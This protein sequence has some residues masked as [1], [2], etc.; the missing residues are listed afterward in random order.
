MAN[1]TISPNMNLVVPTVGLEPGPQFATDINNSL[2]IIDAHNHTAGS[3]VQ[4]TQASLNINGSLTLNQNAL[5]SS[6]YLAFALQSTAPTA[7]T[8]PDSLYADGSGNL[9]YINN[10][11][12][13][14]ITSGN[15]LNVT[16]SGISSGTATAS[17]ISSVLTVFSNASNSTPA[18]IQGGSLLLGN[19]VASSNYVTLEPTSSLSVNYTLTLP[20]APNSSQINPAGVAPLVIDTSGN[21]TPANSYDYL[22]PPGM[23][24]PSGRSSTPPGW[25]FC[26][27]SA[28]SRTTYSNL[29]GA[30]GTAFGNGDGS[31][32]FNV[33]DFQGVFLR[34]VAGAD[35][36]RDP[37]YASRI[38]S[39]SGGNTGNNVG[40]LQFGQIQTHTHGVNDPSHAHAT[41]TFYEAA[42]GT[43]I[44]SNSGIQTTTASGTAAA[45]TG[46]SIQNTGGNQTNPINIYVNYYIKY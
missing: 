43:G 4:L 11:A 1:Y 7:S 15:A 37:D 41:A 5:L 32:T 9:H 42:G 33:P 16:S 38:A 45:V 31:T 28:Y 34:G 39:S 24:M 18:N 40:S 27:G 20:L 26:D 14:Q 44:Q 30:I 29:F 22:L 10:T 23:I 19:N 6:K 12:D 36:G 35:T 2:T 13:I 8:A 17:F 25:L 21:I 46:I 3:G